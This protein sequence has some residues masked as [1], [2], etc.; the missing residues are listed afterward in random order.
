MPDSSTWFQ[1]SQGYIVETLSTDKQTKP[2]QKTK[3]ILL[4]IFIAHEKSSWGSAGKSQKLDKL[5]V[6]P[7]T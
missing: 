1:A 6:S 4:D 7:G 2:F 3:T 5:S